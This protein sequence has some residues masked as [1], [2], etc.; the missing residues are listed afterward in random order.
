[1]APEGAESTPTLRTNPPYR[2]ALVVKQVH[3]PLFESKTPIARE[4]WGRK[5][6]RVGKSPL[7]LF[8]EGTGDASN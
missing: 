4:P 5:L 7:R 6:I 2:G 8:W 3:F 1:V